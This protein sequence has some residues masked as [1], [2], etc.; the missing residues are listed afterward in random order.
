ML[1][2]RNIVFSVLFYA[3]CAFWFLLAMIGYV[4]PQRYFMVFCRGWATSSMWLF[5]TVIGARLEVRGKENIPT[6]G[7]IIAAKHQSSWDTF[8]LL[9]MV[10]WPTY[11]YKREL[12]YIPF[13]GW[14][15]MRAGQIPVDRVGT[16]DVLARLTARAKKALAENRQIIIFPEGTRRAIGAPPDY[17][18]GVAQ[19]YKSFGA[20]C[21]PV[22]LNAGLAWPR[23]RFM[24][25]PYTIIIEF[26]PPIPP[27]LPPRAFFRQMQQVIEEATDRLVDESLAEKGQ[28]RA[29]IQ[30]S[31][32]S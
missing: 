1:L 14:H 24:K 19:L 31:R 2:L 10:A 4:L 16:P 30:S 18:I 8:A 13:F 29:D 12:G 21:V 26:L 25:F 5:S 7:A 15:L 23:R 17:K 11:I 32:E 22:A 3:N 20:P 9:P 28:S 27:G 6:G